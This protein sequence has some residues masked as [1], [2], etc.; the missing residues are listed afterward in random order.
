MEPEVGLEPTTYA[1]Q[2]RCSAVELLR[3]FA[4]VFV[5]IAIILFRSVQGFPVF[6]AL[7]DAQIDVLAAELVGKVGK[8]LFKLHDDQARSP[9]QFFASPPEIRKINLVKSPAPGGQIA[10]LKF[11]ADGLGRS[12]PPSD[13]LQRKLPDLQKIA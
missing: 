3:L 10:E 13:L 12:E 5:F 4:L 1:L 6:G 11:P 9:H 8:A 2:K 7:R